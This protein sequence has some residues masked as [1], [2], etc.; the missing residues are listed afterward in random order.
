MGKI[1]ALSDIHGHYEQ[2]L[3]TLSLVDLAN[4]PKSKLVFLG[5]YIDRGAKGRQVLNHIMTLEKQ[6]PQQVIVLLGNHD[7]VFIDWLTFQEDYVQFSLLDSELLTT[8]NFLPE[9]DYVTYEY[10]F[11]NPYE[12]SEKM[13][14]EIIK[15]MYE[16]AGEILRWLTSKVE[17]SFY[18]ETDTQIFVHAGIEEV[19]K[20]WK[21]MTAEDTFLWKFPAETG[22]F[23]KDIIAGHVS[24][25]EVA[26]DGTYLGKLFWDGESHFF[27]DGSVYHSGVIPLLEYD[28]QTK[29]YFSYEKVSGQ[30]EKIKIVQR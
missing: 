25:A 30:W 20:L 6:Y 1:Y 27:T 28:C 7:K 24:S 18:Y 22:K 19:A 5:D 23:Y 26:K 21:L 4:N 16:N 12:M 10:Y 11:L 13:N 3:D 14:R 9:E 15:T 2:M 8:R 29:T 17:D